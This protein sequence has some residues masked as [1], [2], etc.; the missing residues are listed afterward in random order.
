MRAGVGGGVGWGVVGWGGEGNSLS[1]PN[2]L[3]KKLLSSKLR[4]LFCQ[5]SS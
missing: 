3:T 1:S 4:Q 2:N 5:F